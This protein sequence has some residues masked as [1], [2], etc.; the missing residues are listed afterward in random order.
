MILLPRLFGRLDDGI[1]HGFERE[2]RHLLRFG[3][4]ELILHLILH[5]GERKSALADLR[6]KAFF[7]LCGQR[8]LIECAAGREL[9]TEQTACP[10][11][12]LTGREVGRA[13]DAGAVRQAVRA[14]ADVQQ[15][16]RAAG[17]VPREK[18]AVKQVQLAGRQR[19]RRDMSLLMGHGE[20][21]HGKQMRRAPRDALPCQKTR[22]IRAL[23]RA[24]TGAD[25]DGAHLSLRQ[26]LDFFM[27]AHGML[28]QRIRL[29]QTDRA[30]RHGQQAAAV[31][32]FTG[33]R[34][35]DSR[36]GAV[37]GGI[38]PQK[39]LRH[40]RSPAWPAGIPHAPPRRA[41]R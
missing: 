35:V 9:Q 13:A 7:R 33:F 16:T 21:R 15:L 29:A 10:V 32:P 20:K 26:S 2:P 34:V 31:D 28:E 11:E 19:R 17:Q 41:R 18:F 5:P 8:Q 40:R 30:L 39:A 22:H 27:Q 3:G 36:R 12:Q 25:A 6:L 24:G 37:I 4:P 38:D 14:A 23:H 1:C